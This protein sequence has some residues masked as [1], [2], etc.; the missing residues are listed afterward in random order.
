MLVPGAIST[1][2]TTWIQLESGP[3]NRVTDLD[4]GA[5]SERNPGSFPQKGIKA[6]FSGRHVALAFASVSCIQLQCRYDDRS[7]GSVARASYESAARRVDISYQSTARIALN[8]E[9]FG[10]SSRNLLLT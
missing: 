5:V 1:V 2:A 10:L 7:Q 6:R 8:S 4:L 9:P 3:T